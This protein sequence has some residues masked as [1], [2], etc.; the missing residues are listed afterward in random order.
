M[1][2]LSLF[3]F[4]SAQHAKESWYEKLRDWDSALLLYDKR[5]TEDVD[6]LDLT[7]GRMRCLE[8]MGEW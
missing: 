6:N 4:L 7:L 8:A 5:Q 1:T 2:T 3:G